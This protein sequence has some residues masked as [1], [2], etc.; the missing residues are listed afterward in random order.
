MV[1]PLTH[2]DGDVFTYTPEGENAPDGSG[3]ALT[4]TRNPASFSIDIYAESR[5][6]K[7]VRR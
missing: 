5:V 4:F 6:N 2:W 3:A 7:F 1:F